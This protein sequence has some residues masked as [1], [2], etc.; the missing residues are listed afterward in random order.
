MATQKKLQLSLLVDPHLPSVLFDQ[1]RLSQVLDNLISNSIKYT[2]QGTVTVTAALDG[3]TVK[4]EVKDTGDGIKAEDISKLFSKFEQ[5]GKGK[6]GEK[7]GTGLG[8]VITKGI[9]E[10]HGG[11]IW[12]HSEGLGKGSTFGFSLPLD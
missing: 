12:V 11:K 1:N 2:D 6:S 10:A 3:P 9:V 8:L 5:L 4:V 7:K